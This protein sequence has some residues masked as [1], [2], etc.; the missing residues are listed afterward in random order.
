MQHALTA[1]HGSVLAAWKSTALT[2]SVEPCRPSARP[3]AASIRS[4]GASPEVSVAT[5]GRMSWCIATSGEVYPACR[6]LWIGPPSAGRN[7]CG[8]PPG[9]GIGIDGTGTDGVVGIGPGS[10]AGI[11]GT[12]VL[13]AGGEDGTSRGTAPAGGIGTG[14]IGEGTMGV[15][16]TTVSTRPAPGG[17]SAGRVEGIGRGGSAGQAGN[18]GGAAVAPEDD[19]GTSDGAAVRG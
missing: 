3:R 17:T 15:G 9:G 7:A 10:G 6:T 12:G 8:A 14:T 1:G 5:Y 11:A 18:S 2:W 19:G 16:G 4:D 13:T